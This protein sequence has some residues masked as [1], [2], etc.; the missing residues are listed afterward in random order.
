M[1]TQG[2]ILVLGA[3]GKTGRKIVTNLEAAGAGVRAGSRNAQIPFQ[4]EDRSTWDAALT[5]ISTIYISYYP[6]LAV[7]S[8]P[9]DVTA[10]IELAKAK[11]VKKLVLLSGRGEEEAQ[12]AEKL[13]Q[14][15]GLSWSIVRS[16]WFSQNFSEN[17]LRDMVMEGVL[18]LPN[19]TIREPFIDTDDI[20]AV[21]TAALLDDEH[22]GQ[23]YEVTG[24]ELL[25][26]KEVA[27][28]LSEV[29]GRD[30]Q[31][32]E[33]TPEAFSAGLRQQK[34]PE[35]LVQLVEYLFLTVFDGRNEFVT[36]GV[37]RALG[38]A[39]HSFKEYA[40]QALADGYWN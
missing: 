34:L 29:T 13:V 4:W 22:N 25:T 32:V 6:D 3:T 38:Q 28:Q 24:P 26:F 21:A 7:E 33:I 12:K 9:A 18:A 30:I 23:L 31:F 36:D 20:A 11:G 19:G 40:K 8:A 5:D 27:A 17:F 1:Q 35:D 10:L 2:T 14:D 16:A 15:S 39:P 37:E